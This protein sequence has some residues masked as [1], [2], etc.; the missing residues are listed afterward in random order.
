LRLDTI[1]SRWKLDCLG[2]RVQ[3]PSLAIAEKGASRAI[4]SKKLENPLLGPVLSP[5]SPD[6]VSGGRRCHSLGIEKLLVNGM[7]T[8]TLCP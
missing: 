1:S 7:I 2:R 5:K 8:A 3:L 6:E 4:A